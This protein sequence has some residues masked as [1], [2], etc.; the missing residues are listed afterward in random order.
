MG[1]DP[2]SLPDDIYHILDSETD[3]VVS[4][5]N[6]EWAGEVFKEL[7][8]TRMKKREEKKG[9]EVLRFSAL[10][11]QDRQIWYQAN[12]PETAETNTLLSDEPSVYS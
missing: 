11:K 8:R 5:E 4:E 7:L 10:G 6:V 2:S 9:E 12:K 1:K 3:H